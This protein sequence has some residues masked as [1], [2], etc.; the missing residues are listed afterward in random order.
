MTRFPSTS[1]VSI[2]L[3]FCDVDGPAA[4]SSV[5]F[6]VTVGFSTHSDFFSST[7]VSDGVDVVEFCDSVDALSGEF[8][9]VAFEGI[10]GN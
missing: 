10:G 8:D 7:F 4:L 6:D 9:G 1:N 5:V 3:F 2:E